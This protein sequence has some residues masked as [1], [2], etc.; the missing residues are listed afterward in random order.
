VILVRDG[1]RGWQFAAVWGFSR[2]A[3]DVDRFAVVARQS[4][5]GAQLEL[6]AAPGDGPIA[7]QF[8]VIR[9]CFPRLAITGVV[10]ATLN[11]MALLARGGP[12]FLG[13]GVPTP[14]PSGGLMIRDAK[15]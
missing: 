8:M 1:V 12:V 5:E 2:W 3:V 10:V 9:E 11:G 6:H 15:E 7:P 13:L 14:L 4:D